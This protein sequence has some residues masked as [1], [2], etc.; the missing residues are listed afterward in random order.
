MGNTGRVQCPLLVDENLKEQRPLHSLQIPLLTCSQSDWSP[1]V[2][3]QGRFCIGFPRWGAPGS[4][5]ETVGFHNGRWRVATGISWVRSGKLLNI[6]YPIVHRTVS[7]T[8]NDP[9]LDV[10]S[11]EV[12]K[13]ALG[14]AFLPLLF[15]FPLAPCCLFHLT[16]NVIC[17]QN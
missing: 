3:H 13:P 17:F 12:E 5:L 10:S 4:G 8:K 14:E 2:L 16:P 9:A 11:A 1:V 15:C 7:T 6:P